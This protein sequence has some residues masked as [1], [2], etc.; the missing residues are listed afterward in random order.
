M[1]KKLKNLL[2]V[3]FSPKEKKPTLR[4]MLWR[5]GISINLFWEK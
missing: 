2:K 3:S 5:L 4:I 1:N